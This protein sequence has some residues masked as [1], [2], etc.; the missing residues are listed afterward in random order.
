MKS[1]WV[2]AMIVLTAAGA[3]ADQDAIPR[4]APA[5]QPPFDE[6]GIDQ[7]L[8]A[9]LPMDVPLHD[10]TGRT[11]TLAQVSGGRPMVL[12]LAYYRCPMLCS[13]VLNA[14]AST[15][16]VMRTAG[17]Q[18]GRDYM[19][20]T[21]SIDPRDTTEAASTS[22]VKALERYGHPEDA[23]G[24]RF[25][26]GDEAGV[27]ALAGAAGFRYVYDP[28]SDQYAH[29][30]GI[31]VVTPEG[32]LSHYFLGLEYAP[33]D[34][35]LAL[36]EASAGRIGTLV[37]QIKLLCYRY[38][39][40]TGHYGPAAIGIMRL[41]GVVTVAGLAGFIIVML[42]RERRGALRAHPPEAPAHAE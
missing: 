11:V 40:A 32:S 19:V 21:V 2:G 31:M 12:V 1:I 9:R 7:Q 18:P 35:R 33:K 25:L 30:S 37:D 10:E 26:T 29:A 42:R 4:L 41:G 8:G 28:G 22:R 39:P 23:P 17:M 24:W 20:A 6:I 38:D 5:V 36:V 14:L 27:R 15:M 13:L 3:R 16:D 34:L